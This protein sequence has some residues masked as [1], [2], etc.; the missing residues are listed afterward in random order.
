[1]V[2]AVVVEGDPIAVVADP[3]HRGL[4]VLHATARNRVDKHSARIIA[5]VS[6]RGVEQAGERAPVGLDGPKLIVKGTTAE[7]RDGQTHAVK[8]VGSHGAR[9]ISRGRD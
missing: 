7:E 1:M 5:I 8:A 4:D 2:L 9:T 3:P 6:Q